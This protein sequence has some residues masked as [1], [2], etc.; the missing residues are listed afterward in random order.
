M[1]FVR[2]IKKKSGTYLAL[3]EGKRVGGKVTQK[4]IKYLGKEIGGKPMKRVNPFETRVT[5]VV[6]SADVLVIDKLAKMLDLPSLLGRDA[7]Y[8]LSLVYSHMIERPSISKLEGWFT[9]TEIPAVVGLEEISTVGLY[10][11]LAEL[12][13]KDFSEVEQKLFANFKLREKNPGLIV[14][15]VT[16]TYFEGNSMNWKRRRGKDG[17]YG[18]LL[19]VSLM[20]TR[21][22][23]FPVSM[24]TYPGNVS[25]IYILKDTLEKAVSMGLDG[26]ILDRGGTTKENIEEMLKLGFK[27]VAGVRKTKTLTEQFLDGIRT[28]D[29]Y[30][31]ENRV[32]LSQK[33]GV[34]AKSFPYLGGRIVAVYNPGLEFVRKE[35]GYDAGKDDSDVRHVGYTLIF[36]NTQMEDG[37]A[38][39]MYYKKD[40]VERA[41]RKQKGVLSLRPIR[42]WLKEHVEGHVRVCYL[43]YAVFSLLESL[44]KKQG[45]SALELLENLK[46]GYRVHITDESSGFS[47]TNVVAL[48]KKTM[49]FL[50][51]VGVVYKNG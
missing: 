36:H 46:R 51:E 8:I 48:E 19:Q 39:R 49:D 20:T 14:M 34:Y 24:K 35:I 2:K 28:E 27:M 45:M 15:D 33:N 44:A 26:L 7:P 31:K 38:V 29:I 40:I 3:V 41:F 32:R 9:Q 42:V 12:S 21:E 4:V 47:W 22:N 50:K 37:D 5:K 1:A 16:D 17:K 23:G 30:R 25:N 11:A 18:K 10:D 6:H 13:Q 43:A